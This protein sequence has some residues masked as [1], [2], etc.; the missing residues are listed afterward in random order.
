M[1]RLLIVSRKSQEERESSKVEREDK[2]TT[3]TRKDQEEHQCSNINNHLHQTDLL[4]G[5]ETKGMDHLHPTLPLLTLPMVRQEDQTIVNHHHLHL[6]LQLVRDHQV[7]HMV[8][9]DLMTMTTEMEQS[10]Q[11][12]DGAK[13]RDPLMLNNNSSSHIHHHQD[14]MDH[15]DLSHKGMER[16]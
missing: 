11:W 2:G 9:S 15:L 14:S 8:R 1:R 4:V 6:L 7:H 13:R 12:E 5:K 16:E 10:H 3:T